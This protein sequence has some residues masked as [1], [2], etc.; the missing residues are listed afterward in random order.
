M[1]IAFDDLMVGFGLMILFEGLAYG[2]FPG[3]M[4]R[5]MAEALSLPEKLFRIFGLIMITIGFFIIWL[6]RHP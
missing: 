6:I 1:N 4:R 3:G 2:L 5:M